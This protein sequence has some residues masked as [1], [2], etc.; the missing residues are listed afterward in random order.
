MSGGERIVRPELTRG[1]NR[2]ARPDCRSRSARNALCRIIYNA[3][4]LYRYT[5][6]HGTRM[7]FDAATLRCETKKSGRTAS[8]D[9]WMRRK[10]TGARLEGRRLM[11]ICSKSGEADEPV[12]VALRRGRVVAFC[13]QGAASPGSCATCR[14]SRR[15]RHRT[16]HPDRSRAGTTS[17][18]SC[19]PRAR[20]A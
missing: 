7:R 13:P 9:A 15:R 12:E 4:T 14:R 16:P 3:S 1:C 5:P 19:R 11:N 10:Q 2:A 8:I 17:P 20:A 6:Y 18:T